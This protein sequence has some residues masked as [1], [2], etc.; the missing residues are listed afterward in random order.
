M[1]AADD[2]RWPEIF[3][4]IYYV[5]YALVELG[6]CREINHG[7]WADHCS[8]W[9]FIHSHP[10]VECQPSTICHADLS[11]HRSAS[12]PTQHCTCNRFC[13][14]VPTEL[15]SASGADVTMSRSGFHAQ[16]SQYWDVDCVAHFKTHLTCCANHVFDKMDAHVLQSSGRTC[17][18]EKY[19]FLVSTWFVLVGAY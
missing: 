13:S 6:T 5:K 2:R 19:M 4:R 7:G 12:M 1:C 3:P 15:A 10:Q 11:S 14:Q 9:L 8:L 17:R 18:S 16:V